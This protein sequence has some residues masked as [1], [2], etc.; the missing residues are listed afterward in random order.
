MKKLIPLFIAICFF[1]ETSGQYVYPPT[2]TVDSSNT[3]FGVT[4]KDPYRWLEYIKQ[5]GATAWFK[6]QATYTDSVLNNINGR[7]EL[8]AE[9]EQMDAQ[10]PSLISGRVYENGRIFYRKTNEGN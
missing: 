7:D 10:F 2:K 9:W 3:Y 5:P 6:Q 1:S 8:I 4:Y